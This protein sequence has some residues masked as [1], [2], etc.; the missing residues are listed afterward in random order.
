MK[1]NYFYSEFILNNLI[2][3]LNNYYDYSY[4]WGFVIFPVTSPENQSHHKSIKGMSK[5]CYKG[6]RFGDSGQ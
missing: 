4:V 6:K 2:L 1:E 5:I 3:F